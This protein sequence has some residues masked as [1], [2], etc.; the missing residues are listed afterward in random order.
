MADI[1]S[2]FQASAGV[3]QEELSLMVRTCVYAI[4]L[5]WGGWAVYGQYQLYREG[6]VGLLDLPMKTLRTLFICTLVLVLV[7]VL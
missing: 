3:K 6:K 7:S 1:A 5:L 2:A 4:T